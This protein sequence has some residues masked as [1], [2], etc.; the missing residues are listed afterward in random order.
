MPDAART[1]ATDL[2][3]LAREA[4]KMSDE[5]SARSIPCSSF[6]LLFVASILFACFAMIG[7]QTPIRTYI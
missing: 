3:P 6:L 1:R 5:F 4:E 2:L 7:I